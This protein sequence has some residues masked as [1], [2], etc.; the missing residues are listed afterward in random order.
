MHGGCLF[1]NK[2]SNDALKVYEII[3][4]QQKEELKRDK[5]KPQTAIDYSGKIKNPFAQRLLNLMVVKSFLDRFGFYN[6]DSNGVKIPHWNILDIQDL[7]DS[8]AILVC[9][10]FE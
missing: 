5:I 8:Y 7:F 4:S 9:K 10:K 1:L 2:K 6:V 3:N